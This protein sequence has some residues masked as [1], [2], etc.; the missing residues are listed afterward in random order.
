M[1]I[2]LLLTVLGTLTTSETCA[3][4]VPYSSFLAFT[5]PTFSIDTAG[6]LV[7]TDSLSA[8]YKQTKSPT[9]AM[10][11]S[12]LVPGAGQIYN[13]AYW[14]VPI[15]WGVGGWFVYEW[16]Q[17][18]KSYRDYL[19]R[20]NESITPGLPNGDIRLRDNR[21][22]Y[23]D[24]RDAFAWYLGILYALNI[25]DAYVDAS[26][27]DFNQHASVRALPRQNGMAVNFKISF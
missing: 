7:T 25:L 27:Y 2:A 21:E 1:V 5:S 12:A 13:G 3:Q 15:I 19:H 22:F 23:H 9:L 6:S 20:Y 24:E 11:L 10:G 26:L 18:D 14:K 16:F 4:S 8:P 17:I